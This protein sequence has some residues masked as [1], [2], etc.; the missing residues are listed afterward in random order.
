[1]KPIF[2]ALLLALL[3]LPL[4][5]MAKKKNVALRFFVEANAQDT[6]RFAESV[7]LENLHREIYIEKLPRIN[8]RQIRSIYP[9][10]AGNGTWGATLQLEESGRLDLE[11]LSTAMRGKLIVA[12]VATSAGTH[13][14]ADM[15]IDQPIHD[16][17]ITIPHGLTDIEIGVLS[18]EFHLIKPKQQKGKKEVPENPTN[19]TRSSGQ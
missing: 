3:C 10:P 11:L 7:R 13:Q 19:M 8:E 5:G 1:M 2:R 15:I 12:F 9:F 16:G 14:V 4:L 6:D 18:K 17:I